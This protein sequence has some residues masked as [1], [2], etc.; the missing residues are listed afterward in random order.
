MAGV[1]EQ[2]RAA[3]QEKVF[4]V[5]R[6]A[7]G[8]LSPSMG[9]V[10]LLPGQSGRESHGDGMDDDW[11]VAYFGDAHGVLM[12]ADE[13]STI[14]RPRNTKSNRKSSAVCATISASLSTVKKVFGEP[15]STVEPDGNVSPWF[16]RAWFLVV[17]E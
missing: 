2:A 9:R 15:S 6:N 16:K 17:S 3:A 7:W 14:P 5:S 4:S 12:R 11:E 13:T 10:A 8:G 1:V